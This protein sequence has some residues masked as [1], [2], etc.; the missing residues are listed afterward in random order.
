MLEELL[1]VGGNGT[2]TG[3]VSGADGTFTG[4]VSGADGTFTGNVSGVNGTFTGDG[5]FANGS[6]TITTDTVTANSFDGLATR[7]YQCYRIRKQSIV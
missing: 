1:V 4:N 5:S 7:F 3:N 6:V 2:F